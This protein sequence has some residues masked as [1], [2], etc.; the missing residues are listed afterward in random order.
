[1]GYKS[2]EG[3]HQMEKVREVIAN[4]AVKNIPEQAW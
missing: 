3:E 4:I 1:M 2:C